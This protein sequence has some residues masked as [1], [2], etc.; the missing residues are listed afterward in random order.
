MCRVYKTI[1]CLN[2]IQREL[3]TNNIDEFN[4][5]NELIDFQKNFHITEQSII[6]H[7]SKQIQDEKLYLENEI[8]ELSNLIDNKI[9]ELKNELRKNLNDFNQEI[10]DLSNPNSKIIATIKNYWGNLIIHIKF[11]YI[12]FKLPVTIYI[13]KHSSKK[14][15]SKKNQRLDYISRDFEDAVNKS[16]S[17]DLQK[18]ELKKKL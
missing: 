7:H 10:E 8:S 9:N 18:L 6:S 13:F 16:S 5:I 14:L 12:Q 3:V 15:I 1:G 4:S 17:T 2:T 11:W